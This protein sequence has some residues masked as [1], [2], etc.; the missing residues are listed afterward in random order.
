MFSDNGLSCKWNALKSPLQMLA[1]SIPL[2]KKIRITECGCGEE[3]E[4]SGETLPHSISNGKGGEVILKVGRNC[5][6]LPFPHYQNQGKKFKINIFL[7]LLLSQT[8]LNNYYP[9][10]NIKILNSPL[11][12]KKLIPPNIPKGRALLS[13]ERDAAKTALGPFCRPPTSLTYQLNS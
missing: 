10:P 2:L 3:E 5:K 8:I 1:S 13:Q 4:E 7:L 9:T 11:H 6:V 12:P